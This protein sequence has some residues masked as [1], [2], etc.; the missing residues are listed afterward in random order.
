[1]TTCRT[2]PPA[3]RLDLQL[4]LDEFF[5]RKDGTRR[6]GLSDHHGI[7]IGILLNASVSWMSRIM[8]HHILDIAPRTI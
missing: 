4:A 7:E 8:Q 2:F 5:A 3:S 1:M 6:L